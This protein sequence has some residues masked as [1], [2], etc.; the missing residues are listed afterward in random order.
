MRYNYTELYQSAA[1]GCRKEGVAK[2]NEANRWRKR[3]LSM[4][5]LK[6]FLDWSENVP[7]TLFVSVYASDGTVAICH[8]GVEIG[9]GINTKV[10]WDGCRVVGLCVC[11][12][13]C[14]K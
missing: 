5:P 7:Y 10:R 1:V 6:Y 8:G 9:Q 12:E 13:C 2:F 11:M 14:N 3:G 4:V